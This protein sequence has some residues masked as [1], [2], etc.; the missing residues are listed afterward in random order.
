MTNEEPQ[1]TESPPARPLATLASTQ[2]PNQQ[3]RK[4]LEDTL[5]KV[6]PNTPF[7]IGETKT[8]VNLHCPP[9]HFAALVTTLKERKELAFD[10]LRNMSGV[11]YEE[12]LTCA[13]HFYSFAHN[14]SLQVTVKCPPDNTHIPS[15]TGLY[16]AALWHERE[17]AE[18]FG[19]VFD[20]HPN[21]K[22]LLLEEDL[23]IHPLL[24]AHPLAK[25][26]IL[27]GIEESKPGFDF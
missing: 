22:N 12:G 25:P 7:E 26:E 3:L 9:E 13:Y 5:A 17:A 4:T 11:D 24:K 15:L 1:Q 19:F 16:A 10:M 2:S 20:G 23:N 6:H 18:M 21:L 14:Y 8:D 27:Q